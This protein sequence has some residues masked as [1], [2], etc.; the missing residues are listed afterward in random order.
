MAAEEG[1][2]HAGEGRAPGRAPGKERA[3][4]PD[5]RMWACRALCLKEGK[6]GTEGEEAFQVR[7]LCSMRT[8]STDVRALHVTGKSSWNVSTMM[9]KSLAANVY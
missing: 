3:R 8:G 5:H 7:R 6:N 1:A 9:V 4:E 2:F